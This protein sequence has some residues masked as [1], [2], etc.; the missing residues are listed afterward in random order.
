MISVGR[1]LGSSEDSVALEILTPAREKMVELLQ[2]TAVIG[3]PGPASDICTA[4]PRADH[5]ET[6][7]CAKC[8]QPRR[9][10]IRGAAAKGPYNVLKARAVCAGDSVEVPSNHQLIVRRDIA[11]SALD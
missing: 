7:E 8:K 3:N 1:T 9:V 4:K 6:N 5:R 11:D 10:V 2:R